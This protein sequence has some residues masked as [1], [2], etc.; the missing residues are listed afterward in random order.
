MSSQLTVSIFFATADLRDQMTDDKTQFWL[1][2]ISNWLVSTGVKWQRKVHA[3]K[4]GLYVWLQ[5]VLLVCPVT[6]ERQ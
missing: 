1:S 3:L 5:Y 2:G 4:V 6:D